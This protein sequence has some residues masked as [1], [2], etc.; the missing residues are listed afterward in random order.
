MRDAAGEAADDLH[1][2]RLLQLLLEVTLLRDVG[3]RADQAIQLAGLVVQVEGAVADPAHRAVGADDAIDLVVLAAPRSGVG[4][5]FDALAIVRVHGVHPHAG[6][7]DQALARAAEDRLEGRADVEE[8]A[9]RVGH[10]EHLLDGLGELAEAILRGAPLLLVALALGDVEIDAGHRRRRPVRIVETAAA[11]RHPAHL[12]VGQHDAELGAVDAVAGRPVDPG[13]EL[14]PIRFVDERHELGARLR[15]RPLR[16][17]ADR[18]AAADAADRA[19]AQV[20][21][22]HV[23]AGDVERGI[24]LHRLFPQGVLGAR[25]PAAPAWARARLGQIEPLTAQLELRHDLAAEHAEGVELLG[26]QL[27]RDGIGHGQRAD[28][29][30]VRRA[31]RRAGVEPDERIT[32]DERMVGEA[33]VATQ[34]FDDVE[35]RGVDGVGAER[36][37]ARRLAQRQADSRLEPLSLRVDERQ[38]RDGRLA[39]VGRDPGQIVQDPFGRRLQDLVALQ[40][41]EPPRF[42]RNRRRGLHRN[43][44]TLPPAGPIRH[45]ISTRR[46]AQPRSGS[47]RAVK[48]A[49]ALPGRRHPITPGRAGRT[50]GG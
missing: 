7:G 4:G 8:R 39:H 5:L 41:L 24:E 38:Q 6:V 43:R 23:H 2:L 48:R 25:S 45:G 32:D 26:R 17:P 50:A 33:L 18:P 36:Q 28:G 10:P 21:E 20:G 16:Q 12:A 13:G 46:V 22:P 37:L 44:R 42:V 27:A 9:A 3:G 11:R 15:R 14:G 40:R 35:V 31:Q 30:P 47:G 29:V 49:T 1:L 34:V 19:G